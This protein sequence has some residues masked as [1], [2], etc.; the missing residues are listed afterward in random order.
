VLANRISEKLKCPYVLDY[1]D[2]WTTNPFHNLEHKRRIV[3]RERTITQN[4]A[5]IIVVSSP[6][7]K[8][9][10]DKFNLQNLPAVI[11]NGIDLD[12]W[13]DVQ[14]YHF[15]DFAIVYAGRF[16]PPS[17]TITPV[18]KAVARANMVRNPKQ[19]PIRLHYYGRY[20]NQVARIA[21]ECQASDWCV[22]H[23]LCRR[24]EVL[25]ALRGSGAVAVVVDSDNSESSKYKAFL[26]G[27]LFEALGSG[28]PILA[29]ASHGSE[30]ASVLEQSKSGAAFSG[31]EI[32]EMA[33]WL[34]RLNNNQLSYVKRDVHNFTWQEV[35]SK[36][37]SY[38][39]SLI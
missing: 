25:A 15:D 33:A 39:R 8:E 20:Y 4:A 36:L 12:D 1:R 18:L 38:L 6:W 22:D 21:E 29:V 10:Q 34:Q 16:Y 14:P 17:R 28:S 23:G 37:D 27:K 30:V 35:S 9:L 32:G 7:A 31:S 13:R 3:Q 11:T 5:G 19:R 24:D 26:P 2:P